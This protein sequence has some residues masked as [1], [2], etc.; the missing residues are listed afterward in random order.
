MSDIYL[1]FLNKTYS[2]KDFAKRIK[3]NIQIKNLPKSLSSKKFI[4]LVKINMKDTKGI[5]KQK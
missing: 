5:L 3:I 2:L 4:I 1:Y